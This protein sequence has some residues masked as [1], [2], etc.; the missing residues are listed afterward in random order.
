MRCKYSY[1]RLWSRKALKH[2]LN[3]HHTL[4]WFVGLQP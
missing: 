2:E 3:F 4:K 1:L